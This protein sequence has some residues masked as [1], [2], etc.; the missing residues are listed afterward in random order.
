MHLLVFVQLDWSKLH[1]FVDQPPRLAKP[2]RYLVDVTIITMWGP[3][4]LCLLVS[5]PI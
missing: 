2:S 3:Q 5:N 1:Q 4:T